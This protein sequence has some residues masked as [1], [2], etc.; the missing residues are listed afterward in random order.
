MYRLNKRD[1]DGSVK[2]L[3]KTK[4]VVQRRPIKNKDLEEIVYAYTNPTVSTP[5]GVRHESYC[6][7]WSFK[8]AHGIEKGSNNGQRL[9]NQIKMLKLHVDLHVKFEGDNASNVGAGRQIGRILCLLD[10]Q[11]NCVDY[12]YTTITLWDAQGLLQDTGAGRWPESLRAMDTRKRFIVLKDQIVKEEDWPIQKTNSDF[13]R[14]RT[15][16]HK[17]FSIP[18][19]YKVYYEEDDTTTSGEYQ[20]IPKNALYLYYLSPQDDADVHIRVVKW[21]TR[22]QYQD[23]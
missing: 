15:V 23:A 6:S 14:D 8:P 4:L 2:S 17:R 21:L 16:L 9:G 18:L 13:A 5:G 12:P 11:S 22:L 7:A 3:P 19:G 10:T 20:S 1:Y